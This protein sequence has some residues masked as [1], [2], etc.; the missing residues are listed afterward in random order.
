MAG[1]SGL[2]SPKQMGKTNT[3]REPEGTSNSCIDGLLR[4]VAP[5]VCYCQNSQR[6]TQGFKVGGSIELPVSHPE[7]LIWGADGDIR[8]HFLIV[9]MGRGRGY[10]R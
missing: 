1:E 4:G 3:E 8:R 9:T 10:Y 6:K 2:N 5:T 7:V